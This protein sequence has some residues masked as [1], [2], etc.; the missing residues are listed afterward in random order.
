M[1]GPVQYTL[2]E[3]RTYIL[4]NSLTV[5][6]QQRIQQSKLTD[7]ELDAFLTKHPEFAAKKYPTI[8]TILYQMD[9]KDCLGKDKETIAAQMT[10][11]VE[12]NGDK[13]GERLSIKEAVFS[14]ETKHQDLLTRPIF[15]H[16][17]M[18]A[19]QQ[20]KI[21]EPVF[22]NRHWYA[23]KIVSVQQAKSKNNINY[24]WYLMKYC[25]C[26]IQEQIETDIANAQIQ[27]IK[28]IKE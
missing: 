7:A 18:E 25:Q 16:A 4:S 24:E 27:Q 2:D 28:I 13:E 1:Y 12:K 15:F 17:V 21:I 9:E 11:L 19:P 14:E 26:Q 5:L 22:E 8:Q 10:E 3:Y 6:E 20:G 23:A